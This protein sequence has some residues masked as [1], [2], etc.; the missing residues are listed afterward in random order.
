MERTCN[1]CQES[2]EREAT[3]VLLCP[4]AKSEERKLRKVMYQNKVIV[5]IYFHI[6]NDTHALIPETVARR[7]HNT[8]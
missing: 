2:G 3:V 7:I 8:V 5:K 4:K 6:D 1:C